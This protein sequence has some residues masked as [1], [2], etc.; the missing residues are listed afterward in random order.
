MKR[1]FLLT[2]LLGLMAIFVN[3]QEPRYN[4]WYTGARLN[5]VNFPIGGIGAG[6]VGLEGN[7]AWSQM[8]VANKPNVTHEPFAFA[9]IA[10]K[11]FPNSAKVLQG[12]V[13]DWKVF[14]RPNSGG[15]RGSNSY[16]LPRFDQCRFSARF[17]FGI[18]ELSDDDV[19]LKVMI[20]GWSPF[21]PG[22]T[23]NSSLPVGAMEYTFTNSSNQAIDA[24]FSFNSRNII[25]SNELNEI[26]PCSNGYTMVQI[27]DSTNPENQGWFSVFTNEPA[28]V[29]HCWFR[30]DWFDP[31]TML[32]KDI[33]EC[34]LVS[35]V[36]KGLNPPGA[37]LFVP[38]SLKPGETK[39]INL[40]F[41]WYF[42]ETRISSGVQPKS[43]GPAF[44]D[45]P[46]PGVA[47]GQQPLNGYAGKQ[48]IN[49]FYPGGDALTGSLTSP[50]F[51]IEKDFIAFL[52]GGG[53][54]LNEVGMKL[55]VDGTVVR[56]ATGRDSENLLAKS[57]DVKE[58]K[59]KVAVI[60]VFDHSTIEW[61]HILVDQI[62]FT[63]DPNC[64][65]YH[66]GASDVV[67][68]GFEGKDYG[69]WTIPKPSQK[70]ANCNNEI[71]NPSSSDCCQQY[72]KPWYSVRFKSIEEVANYWAR[73]YQLL[74]SGTELFTNTFYSSTLPSEVMEAVSA[75]L[76]ILK[77]PTILRD[78]KGRMWAWEGC[79]DQVGCCAGSCTHV[80][81][82][83]QAIP[84]L[85]PELERTLRETEFTVSQNKE[86]HQT[87]RAALPISE[88][89]HTF[90]AA[91]DGQLGGIM[92][93]Y[94]DWRIS[95]DENWLKK[96]YPLVKASLDYCIKT[97]D[98][99]HIGVLI[100]PHHNTY[101]IEFWGPDGMCSSFYIGAL[102]SFIEISKHLGQP[103]VEYEGLLTKGKKYIEAELFNGEYFNQKIRWTDLHAEDPTRAA[104]A[105]TNPEEAYQLLL[106]EGPKYQYGNGCLSDGVLGMWMASVCGLPEVL[107]EDKVTRH[108]VSVHKYNLR[109]DLFDHDNPQRPAFA[110]GHEAGLLICTWPH[111]GQLSLPFVYSNEVWTG[112]EYQVASHLMLHGEVEKGLDIVR[113]CRDRYNGVVRNPFD[114]YECGHW[115]AR[116]LSSY[117]L[118]QGLT[119]LRYDAV[120]KTLHIKSQIGNNFQAFISTATGYGLAGL[121]DGKPFIDVKSGMIP[122]LK[123]LVD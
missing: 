66:P 49:T 57:W 116:A 45:A 50:G 56:E 27:G 31:L 42:P 80:W 91:S 78:H 65:P 120:D 33:R 118:I 74:R 59:G 51:K 103:C 62:V 107:N 21:V 26:I 22:D 94:R 109:Q 101:D 39:T 53:D 12:P 114:E 79:N 60:E 40:M 14:S 19:P 121:K 112:I 34:N 2:G 13:P 85:F 68:E 100:E 76:G 54:F 86:G 83:A 61:G 44:E 1:L 99:D 18:I 95:A 41:C 10:V 67:Y 98:P 108:L 25:S 48:L 30:G 16:G 37:S 63:D 64:N 105:A 90:H 15:G 117:G 123:F 23:D 11:G 111:G 119:G 113:A 82:Y 84:H 72:Y 106:K 46:A 58:L 52:I 7:G 36:P 110:M 73:N 55:W 17:P 77:S 93:V 70:T 122:V 96:L 38:V 92:K 5:H 89:R 35:D 75:N 6:M 115:Y 88:P 69:T 29:D 9:A 8:S 28:V 81:N 102:T 24:V 71:C 43:I 20:K 3:G 47:V 87:F 32:W 97:W 104:N 4:T